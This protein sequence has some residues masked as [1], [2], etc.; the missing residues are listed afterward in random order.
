MTVVCVYVLAYQTILF[1]KLF[2]R[3]FQTN[4]LY[5]Y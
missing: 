1:K 5:I 4:E 3:H 2:R